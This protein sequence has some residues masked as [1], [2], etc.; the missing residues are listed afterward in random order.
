MTTPTKSA[1]TWLA[2]LPVITTVTLIAGFLLSTGGKINELADHERR[3][4]ALEVRRDSDA[5]K[6]DKINE[7]TARI[8]AKVEVLLPTGASSREMS[9]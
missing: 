2:W 4:A 9:R 8:E 3:L 5:D 6:L 1:P 7:R